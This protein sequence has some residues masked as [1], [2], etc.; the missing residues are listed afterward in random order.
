[1]VECAALA[2]WPTIDE[3]RGK[4]IVV[5]QGNWSTAALDWALYASTD[6]RD[7]VAFPM[8]SVF[9]LQ[10]QPGD[11]NSNNWFKATDPDGTSY[12]ISDI[13]TSA[14]PCPYIDPATRQT[15]FEA[16]VFWQ[17]E[18]LGPFALTQS[19][20]FLR[21]GGVIRGHDAYK[22]TDTDTAGGDDSV[23][24]IA[25]SSNQ[26]SRVSCFSAVMAG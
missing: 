25:N 13:D 8:Q 20:A 9:S 12:W 10:E 19:K 6:L 26:A 2:G 23:P 15:A 22:M 1:M 24:E 4:F 7:R 21:R 14:T 18:D 16:S 11:P 5:L 17:L 3:L